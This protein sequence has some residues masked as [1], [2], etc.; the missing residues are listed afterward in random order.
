MLS[1]PR[2]SPKVTPA[3]ATRSGCTRWHRILAAVVAA[4]A[5][6][7]PYC[8]WPRLESWSARW[9]S[10]GVVEGIL[11]APVV[12]VEPVAVA[13]FAARPVVE[14][15]RAVRT[16][17][18]RWPVVLEV[19]RQSRFR[20]RNLSFHVQLCGVGVLRPVSATLSRV[21]LSIM[22]AVAFGT[23]SMLR[24]PR[25]SLVFSAS[26]SISSLLNTRRTMT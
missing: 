9:S 13:R 14:S 3:T 18:L 15:P 22:S 6:R 1:I 11:A 25:I 16:G 2:D 12:V 4:R 21:V 23:C 8:Q 24:L 7:E 10:T 5:G 20:V 26:L 17:G 19:H